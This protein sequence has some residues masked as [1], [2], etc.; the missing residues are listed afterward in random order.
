MTERT[1]NPNPSLALVESVQP[2]SSA[3]ENKAGPAPDIAPSTESA[4][5]PPDKSEKSY[6]WTPRKMALFLRHLGTRQSVA[7][8]A[9]AVG[10]SRQSAYR[11]R[12][13]LRDTSFDLA[14]EAALQLGYD[15]LAQVA[16]D[17]ALN[18]V[19]VPH[20]YRG[21]LV[22]TTRRYDEKLTLALLAARSRMG[23]V[24]AAAPRR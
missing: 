10:M 18:G 16:L 4:A 24:P 21:E 17:R 13:R 3:S 15:Q 5:S 9:R 11:L 1:K 20:Y 6:H 8:A 14:W 22:G 12:Q 19:E 23:A 7:G 2:S